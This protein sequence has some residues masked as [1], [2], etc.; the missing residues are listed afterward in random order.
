MLTEN[1]L[2]LVRLEKGFFPTFQESATSEE[3]KLSD[4]EFMTLC[5][6]W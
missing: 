2:V 1:M 4:I 5:F 3:I 6:H